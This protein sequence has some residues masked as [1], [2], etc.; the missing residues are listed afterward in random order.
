[1]STKE[2]LRRIILAMAATRQG[3]RLF[4]LYVRVIDMPISRLTK[5]VFVPSAYWNIMPIIYLTTTG[6]KSGLPHSIPVL[7][8]SDGENLILVGSNWGNPKNPSWAYNLRMHPQTQVR[9]GKTVKGFTA[10][11]LHGDERAAYWQ[12]AVA[13]YPPYVSYEQHSSRSL[14][15]FLLEP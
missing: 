12:K 15:I 8:I 1:M 11:E 14:P 2:R 6:A 5:G 7:C 3:M 4:Y 13:F 10:R 9:K